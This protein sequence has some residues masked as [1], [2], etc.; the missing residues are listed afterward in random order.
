MQR[1]SFFMMTLLLYFVFVLPAQVVEPVDTVMVNKIK[2]EGLNRSQIMETLSWLTDVYG[3]RLGWS[4]EYKQAAEWA[5]A[6]LEKWGLENAHLE[7]FGPV[8][9]GWTLR[10]LSANVTEPRAYPLIAYAKAWSPGTKGTVRGPVVHL[11]AT[12]DEELAAYKGKLKGAV[13]LMMP[14]RTLEAMWQAPATRYSDSQLLEMANAGIQTPTFRA[15]PDSAARARFMQQQA[16]NARKLQFIIDEGAVAQFEIAF[17]GDGGTVFVQGATVPFPPET[18]QANRFSAYSPEAEKTRMIP[19]LVLT[20][21]HY[22]R[23]VRQLEKGQRVRVELNLEVEFTKA[24]STYNIIAEIPGTDLKDEIVMVGGHFDSWHAGTGATDN[25]TGSSVAMEAMRILKALSVQPRRT[26]RIGLWGSEEQGL[27]G[28]RAYVAKH[29]GERG[30]TRFAPAGPVMTKPGHEKFSV[31]FN[32][33]NGTGKVRGVYL[34]G[35]DAARPIFRSWLAP[36]AAMDASTLTLQNTGGTDHLAFDAVGL[37]G[38]QFIQDEI[39]YS[40]RT[41]HSNMD[42]YDRVQPDDVKQAAVIMAAF[43]YH[44]AMRDELFPRKPVPQPA[45]ERTTSGN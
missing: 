4:P 15:T 2:D 19:Q 8:G 34:Q 27:V 43:A 1:R 25:A 36:F 21:E 28:S 26:I 3:P 31:Y 20:P 42:V 13:V 24:D 30:G 17:K 7:K 12:T 23:M 22:N 45:G 5:R 6:Q 10:R 39:E 41:H 40:P 44:A 9:R 37:P 16:F 29:L 14:P 38:F 32:N 33:D 11:T 18:P 35:N